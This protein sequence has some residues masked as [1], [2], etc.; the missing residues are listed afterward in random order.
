MRIASVSLRHTEP[1]HLLPSRSIIA[2]KNDDGCGRMHRMPVGTATECQVEPALEPAEIRKRIVFAVVEYLAHR[3]DFDLRQALRFDLRF[4]CDRHPGGEP[5]PQAE[6][7]CRKRR[8][9][10]S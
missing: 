6:K 3:K 7:A 1:V 9:P 8:A 2:G 5:D 10:W 4:C